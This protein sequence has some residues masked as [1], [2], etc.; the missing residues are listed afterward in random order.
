MNRD[1]QHLLLRR[2]T[3]R[4]FSFQYFCVLLLDNVPKHAWT[5]GE[6]DTA[7]NCFE[8]RFVLADS[9]S[10]NAVDGVFTVAQ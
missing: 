10:F 4:A 8:L 9:P 7:E 3:L 6:A 1:L 5:A 2:S